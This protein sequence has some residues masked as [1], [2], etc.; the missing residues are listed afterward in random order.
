MDLGEGQRQRFWWAEG[1]EE[2]ESREEFWDAGCAGLGVQE[3]GRRVCSD[4]FG[5]VEGTRHLGVQGEGDGTERR[6]SG[7][8]E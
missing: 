6:V 7:M 4:R 2:E 8:K 1:I 3:T 5:R